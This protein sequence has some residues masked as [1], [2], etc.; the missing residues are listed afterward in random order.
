MMPIRYIR[1]SIQGD[2]RNPFDSDELIVKALLTAAAFV[3]LADGQVH[4][5]EREAAVHYIDRRQL[6]TTISRQRVA[7]FFDERA[8]RF[9]DADAADLIAEGLRPVAALSLTSDVI[10]LAELV[11]AADRH[12]DRNEARVIGLIRLITT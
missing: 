3:A 4:V 10:A 2:L 6:A 9:E 11:A 8:Q 5:V 7:A 12:V 1:P